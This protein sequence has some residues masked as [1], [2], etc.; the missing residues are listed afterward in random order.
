M[1]PARIRLESGLHQNWW[2][3]YDPTTGRYTQVDPLGFVDGP[4]VYGYAR[5]SSLAYA[6]RTGRR[7][8][9]VAVGVGV[10]VGAVGDLLWQLANGAG[11]DA[12]H[13]INWSEVGGSALVGGG[14]ALG[15][16][17]LPAIGEIGFLGNEGG[18]L[19]GLA[20]KLHHIFGK[21]G[22]NLSGFLN[23]FGG[24][25]G[26]AYTTIESV[27]Q[28]LVSSGALSGVFETTVWVNGTL[29]TVRGKVKDGIVYIRTALIP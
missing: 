7:P 3:H 25:E 18:A 15:G 13:L 1:V 12:C 19:G 8:L 29:I 23:S 4:S 24:S 9:C 27:T 28:A 22:H 16:E 26:A 14:V 10:A 20:N 21:S 11:S 2:R 5:G 17:L 6:D